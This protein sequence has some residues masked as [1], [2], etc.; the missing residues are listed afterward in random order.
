MFSRKNEY[1]ADAYAVATYG[2]P[3]AMISAL[4]KLC[5][6]N[7]SNLTPHPV[8]VFLSYGHPPILERIKRIRNLH[9]K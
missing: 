8:K 7:L 2:K 3:D 1:E 6:D 9:L 4:K 5:V